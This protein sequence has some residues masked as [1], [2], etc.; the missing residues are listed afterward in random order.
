MRTRKT[1]LRKTR[2]KPNRTFDFV[3]LAVI[4]VVAVAFR[5][6]GLFQQPA[7]EATSFWSNLPFA[8]LGAG[9]IYLIYLI[10]RQWFNRK[11]GL[12]SAAFFAVS[13]FTVVCNQQ[14]WPLALGLFFVLLAAWF[15][16]KIVF[17]TKMPAMGIYV[18]F[19]LSILVCSLAHGF[20]WIQALLIFLT[21]WIWLPRERRK[22]Y[23]INGI[24][25]VALSVPMFLF[26]SPKLFPCDS[27][28]AEVSVPTITFFTDFLQYTMNNSHLFIFVA[29]II[30]ILPFIIG[31]RSRQRNPLRWVGVG[32]FVIVMAAAIAY[33]FLGRPILQYNTLIFCYPF[34][35]IVAFS[36]FKS[37][38][39]SPWQTALAVAAIL[40]AGCA[41]LVMAQSTGL[42]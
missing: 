10:G 11:A 3:I 41:S 4:M 25:S 1:H 40:F 6:R 2:N 32:W 15:W 23:G 30:V 5:L 17:G 26:L 42:F 35:I 31:K 22:W 19:A 33:S 28:G 7:S 34:L 8:L 13:Q 20:A 39:L 18:G 29:G 36:L 21:G 38:T 27:L 24:A 9:S 37:R 16:H 12:F 14:T